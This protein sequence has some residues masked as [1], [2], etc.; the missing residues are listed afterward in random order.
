M[1][2]TGLALLYQQCSRKLNIRCECVVCWPHRLHRAGSCRLGKHDCQCGWNFR[3]FWV[4]Y[5]LGYFI[6]ASLWGQQFPAS[7]SHPTT[8]HSYYWTCVY[9]VYGAHVECRANF[10]LGS[11]GRKSLS[12]GWSILFRGS[13]WAPL[14][15]SIHSAPKIYAITRNCSAVST[16]DGF[17]QY[18]EH[19]P[20][21]DFHLLLPF[22][23]FQRISGHGDILDRAA[24][25]FAALHVCL[26]SAGADLVWMVSRVSDGVGRVLQ[27]GDSRLADG[28]FGVVV[29]G[30]IDDCIW[31]FRRDFSGSTGDSPSNRLPI[32]DD[33]HR[34]SLCCQYPRWSSAGRRQ[35]LHGEAGSDSITWVFSQRCCGCLLFVFSFAKLYSSTFHR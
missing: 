34:N 30:D 26:S 25:H 23:I 18:F 16:F 14:Q 12:I 15:F 28:M 31:V 32:V 13:I 17:L 9:F 35:T 3:F 20:E 10:D 6:F 24:I 5:S 8:S 22:G 1:F 2:L 21:L 27:S 11:T 33:S 19:C 7:W 4:E 29:L